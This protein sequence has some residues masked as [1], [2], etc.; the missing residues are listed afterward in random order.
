MGLIRDTRPERQL[1]NGR[2]ATVLAIQ[3]GG[4]RSPGAVEVQ[5]RMWGVNPADKHT[6]EVGA[7]I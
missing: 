1:A 2:K 3:G 5:V 6:G 7:T 4:K